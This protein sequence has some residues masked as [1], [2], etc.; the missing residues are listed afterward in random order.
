MVVAVAA[1]IG[2][3]VYLP[4]GLDG[5]RRL[6]GY[7]RAYRLISEAP[8]PWESRSM[9]QFTVVPSVTR[10]DNPGFSVVGEY[11]IWDLRRLAHAGNTLAVV[12]RSLLT[13]TAVVVRID[14]STHAYRY[15]YQTSS[16]YFNAW[17][18][19]DQ[20][21]ISLVTQNQSTV[22]GLSLLKAWQVNIDVSGMPLQ[23]QTLISVQSETEDAFK[24]RDDWWAAMAITD[25]VQS[26]SM[27]ILFPKDLPYRT[28][29][30]LRYPN[31]SPLEATAFEGLMLR[32]HEQTELVWEIDKPQKGFT[33]KV[34]WDW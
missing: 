14:A 9:S 15:W 4:S 31:D 7:A 30:F 29:V 6:Y 33:Y 24:T 13:R 20:F 18:R 23:K 27:R 19:G 11:R 32:G 3:V 25:Q 2:A 16:R 10:P 1:L 34:Q 12:G 8:P 22:T 21:P 26:A 5:I 17:S 28:A